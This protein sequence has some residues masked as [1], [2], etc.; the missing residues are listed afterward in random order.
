[1]VQMQMRGSF[2]SCQNAH[3]G[4]VC[5]F[6]FFSNYWFSR[7]SFS[8]L[9]SLLCKDNELKLLTLNLPHVWN[10]LILCTRG[11]SL[12]IGEN[13]TILFHNILTNVN[14]PTKWTLKLVSAIFIK[15]LFF[16]QMIA[17][18]KLWKMLFISS[19][20]PFSF[21]RYSNFCISIFPFFSLS[22]IALEVDRR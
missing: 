15:F 13:D 1:M 12:L 20:K 5:F 3:A 8:F 6:Q 22:A 17:L 18:Q 10:L 7:Y 19:K 11:I 21:L 4:A 9:C 2:F 16:H 14:S